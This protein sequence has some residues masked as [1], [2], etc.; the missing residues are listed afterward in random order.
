MTIC[1]LVTEVSD[2]FAL[3]VAGAYANANE[4]PLIVLQLQRRGRH[5]E[6]A[7]DEPLREQLADSAAMRLAETACLMT[8]EVAERGGDEACD[9]AWSQ[10]PADEPL[11]SSPYAPR[12]GL[13]FLR[14]RGD[15]PAPLALQT[16]AEAG[17]TRLFVAPACFGRSGLEEA[18]RQIS[19]GASCETILLQGALAAPALCRHILV[20]TA[21]GVHASAALTGAARVAQCVG[22]RVTALYV[23]AA[24]DEVAPLVGENILKSVARRALGKIPEHVELRV[25]VADSF[26]EG[27][28]QAAAEPADFVLL[29]A[30]VG[31][32]SRRAAAQLAPGAG[33]VGAG[34]LGTVRAAESFPGRLGRLAS[35]LL[36]THV[37]QLSRDGRVSL[38]ERV[39]SSSQWNFD[40]T[41]LMCLSTLIA[42]LGLLLNSASVVIGAMLI[43]PLMTPIVA[44]GLAVVQGNALLMKQ[45]VRSLLRG[46]VLAYLIA[47]AVGL[48]C[49]AFVEPGGGWPSREML[50]R[51]APNIL[52]LIVAFVSGVA[53]AY[54]MGRPNLSS[55]LPG[56]AIAAALIPPIGVAGIATSWGEWRLMSG[57][58]LLFLTNII[59]IALATA[60]SLRAVGIRDTHP[61]GARQRWS[62]I[63]AT[64]LIIVATTLAI[65]E[66]L[67]GPTIDA[68]LRGEFQEIAA[69]HDCDF[70]AASWGEDS[71]REP[72]IRI[73][74]ETPTAP[75]PELPNELAF[76]AAQHFGAPVEVQLEIRTVSRIV[77]TRAA[78]P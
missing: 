53:A 63:A 14:I 33:H 70:A 7:V 1:L 47:I 11:Q 74:V 44:S 39:Q 35:R 20:A 49:L 26:R 3:P 43:A 51:G 76:A 25:E 28:E 22:G 12:H 34:L 45:A 73:V 77:R 62:G 8:A 48:V 37:P 65:Y 13:R 61:H 30:P 18:T 78:G 15:D 2:L 40:F 17:A 21:G 16:L 27:V 69:S 75:S 58:L 29:G 9:E 71:D 6:A 68:E 72:A 42:A 36:Q 38:V 50:S 4:A 10:T 46:F 24:V 52:D 57:A 55:A 64:L 23:E 56:V 60:L 41:A 67:P 59:A 32:E 19:R 54:A 5:A 31:R 66:S